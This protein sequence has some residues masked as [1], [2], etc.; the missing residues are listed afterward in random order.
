MLSRVPGSGCF[1]IS[2]WGEAQLVR[3]WAPPRPFSIAPR[4]R[5]GQRKMQTS[6]PFSVLLQSPG[7]RDSS[8]RRELGEGAVAGEDSRER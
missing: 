5:L 3:E 2:D 4:E 1:C 7:V 6:F 8:Q